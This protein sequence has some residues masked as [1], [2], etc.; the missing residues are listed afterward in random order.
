MHHPLSI[1]ATQARFDRIWKRKNGRIEGRL[2]GLTLV[3][4]T[5]FWLALSAVTTSAQV[6]AP[7]GPPP[8]ASGQV[9]RLSEVKNWGYQLQGID[10]DRVANSPYELVVVDY[11]RNGEDSGTFSREQVARMQRRP[12][13]SRRIVLAYMSIGEAEDYRFYWQED[14]VR[15]FSVLTPDAAPANDTRLPLR[16]PGERSVVTRPFRVPKVTAPAW[17]GA[18][19]DDWVGNFHVRFWDPEWQS[20]ILTSAN[21]YLNRIL[22]AGFDGVYLDRIDAFQAVIDARGQARKEMVSFVLA[23]AAAARR[24]APGFLVVPQNGEQ[25]LS[26]PA[27]LSVID[28]IAKEDLLYGERDGAANPPETIRR[29]ERWLAPAINRDLPVLVVEYVG[30][31][32]LADTLKSQISGRGYIPY[33]GVRALDHLVLTEDL[34]ADTTVV[35]PVQ[36]GPAA[37]AS[38]SKGA[39][40]ASTTARRRLRRD[41]D[42]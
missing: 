21:S 26:D 33:I 42:R 13:G 35:T 27:Y 1:G 32:A 19:S 38:R 31:R 37:S 18:E 28:A 36:G 14:W 2:A 17:L 22:D 5:A 25:L 20:V 30:T 23:I 16:Q 24:V 10:I 3:A 15:T 9:P 6:I 7:T 40:K 4:T 39:A 11:S 12:D 41:R 29:S 34:A 8:V